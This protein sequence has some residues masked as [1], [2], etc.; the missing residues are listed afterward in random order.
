MCFQHS[1]LLY[2]N[3]CIFN[4]RNTFLKILS[5]VLTNGRPPASTPAAH[6]STSPSGGSREN[7]VYAALV[8]T[9]IIG[10]A[11]YVSVPQC[12]LTSCQCQWCPAHH[13][14]FVCSRHTEPSKK[15]RKDTRSASLKLKPGRPRNKLHPPRQSL[16]VSSGH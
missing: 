11:I 10:G 8:G 9:A 15:T 2:R 4:L 3:Q 13:I 12:D 5:S 1:Q 7:Q 6:M 16:L 14:F